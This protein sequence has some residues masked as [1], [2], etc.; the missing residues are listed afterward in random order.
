MQVTKAMGVM[1]LL[2][3]NRERD[4]VLSWHVLHGRLPCQP[5][6]TR[7]ALWHGTLGG[8]GVGSTHNASLD[9]SWYCQARRLPRHKEMPAAS[10]RFFPLDAHLA[11]SIVR[12]NKLQETMNAGP[13]PAGG[14]CCPVPL[15]G[16]GATW[17]L[18]SQA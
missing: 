5:K 4:A 11:F 12:T 8:G 6:A 14:M 7:L 16:S 18:I 3:G 17:L 10:P 15:A 2:K 1:P 9:L 13:D